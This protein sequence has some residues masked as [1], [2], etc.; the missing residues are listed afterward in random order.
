MKKQLALV[1]EFHT[2]FKA[3]VLDQP[4]LI[5]K[6]RYELRHALMKDEVAEYLTG[7]ESGDLEN[8]SKELADI[9]YAVY[10]SI[11][12]HGLQD[13]MEEIFAEVHKSNMSK[14]YSEFKMKKGA[15]YVEADIK[16]FIT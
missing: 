14:E 15:D 13:K 11:L 8:I 6:D 1:E 3:P 9:L 4:S 12:E 16:K 2:K 5:C 10:G 7:A